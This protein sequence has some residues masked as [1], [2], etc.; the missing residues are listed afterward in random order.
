VSLFSGPIFVGC[1]F[2]MF[3][4]DCG[5]SQGPVNKTLGALGLLLLAAAIVA[6][7]YSLAL[8]LTI[9]GIA[10]RGFVLVI[11]LVVL[12]YDV[13]VLSEH[14]S[15][16]RHFDIVKNGDIER[17]KRISARYEPQILN[18]D[19]WTAARWGR[20]DMLKY[21]LSRGADPNADYDRKGSILDAARENLTERPGKNRETV[22]F[23]KDAGVRERENRG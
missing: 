10:N 2:L 11:L 8:L 4:S 7:L 3:Y 18:D 15:E 16:S 20:I 21:L 19:L 9:K 6:F 12:G 1:W 22:E 5:V 23:L 17:Y 14:Y 13:F